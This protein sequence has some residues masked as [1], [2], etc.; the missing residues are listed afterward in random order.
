MKNLELQY[1]LPT[2][3]DDDFPL[4]DVFPTFYARYVDRL[5]YISQTRRSSNALLVLG[6]TAASLCK[7]V[8]ARGV[9]RMRCKPN[10]YMLLG[11]P[12]GYGKSEGYD[13][14][15]A[16]LSRKFRERTKYQMTGG[17]AA[18]TVEKREI[19]KQKT[20]YELG[21]SLDSG[22][23][24]VRLAPEQRIE[25]LEAA[26][27]RLIE[28]EGEQT[29]QV[30]AGRDITSEGLKEVMAA[31]NG[32]FFSATPD[33]KKTLQIIN[34]MY[35]KG[36]S[37]ESGF[38][39]AYNWEDDD[40]IRKGGKYLF[41]EKPCANIMWTAPTDLI[42]SLVHSGTLIQSG[43]ISRC[44]I[45][46][47]PRY[48]APLEDRGD[49]PDEWRTKYSEFLESNLERF[50]EAATPSMIE[51]EQEA[52][53]HLR[54]W[55]NRVKHEI[56]FELQHI[57]IQAARWAEHAWRIALIL[58]CMWNPGAETS[59]CI[60]LEMVKRATKI[61]EWIICRQKMIWE[62]K[63]EEE[64]QK[65]WK[66]VQSSL[67]K[68]SNTTD[69]NP[70]KF[71]AATARSIK[72]GENA[73]FDDLNLTNSEALAGAL[74][75]FLYK[76]TLL[77]LRVGKGVYF[78]INTPTEVARFCHYHG[79]DNPLEMQPADQ[80]GDDTNTIIFDESE[81]VKPPEKDT[82]TEAPTAVVVTPFFRF[83]DFD[84]TELV[85]IPERK[86]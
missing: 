25:E 24:T 12:V 44:I 58:H 2:E 79:I 43:F 20:Q 16:P 34:G 55:S 84:G 30:F 74:Q 27:G 14:F 62:F 6:T 31:N 50:L 22:G 5:S 1:P 54:V 37:D 9:G 35:K 71:M 19:E 8:V 3:H 7:G 63:G 57:E 32:Y 66:L 73:A 15:A 51:F 78:I 85:G 75:P 21:F 4:Y 49:I 80:D 10:L 17:K 41:V 52:R 33:A 65:I 72:R 28:I 70:E 23:K 83:E 76:G 45:Q 11:A 82:A 29:I 46:I 18:N 26:E 60:S 67:K 38:L 64:Q 13:E 39:S 48:F 40:S 42:C 68:W 61:A 69:K 56:F 36:E 53:E 59:S 77:S 81:V 47:E 86:D